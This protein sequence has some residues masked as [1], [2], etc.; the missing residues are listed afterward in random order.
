MENDVGSSLPRGPVK[1]LPKVV[2]PRSDLLESI[3]SGKSLKKVDIEEKN[4]QQKN[5]VGS[6]DLVNA[7]LKKLLDRRIKVGDSDSEDEDD[8]DNKECDSDEWD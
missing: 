6:D 2:D 5:E 3:R 1:Q 7:L 8:D 4:E